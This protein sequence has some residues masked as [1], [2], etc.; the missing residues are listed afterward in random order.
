MRQ[1]P[2]L[3]EPSIQERVLTFIAIF[4][5]G[6]TRLKSSVFGLDLIGHF[7]AELD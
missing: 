2:S 7:L 4:P 5:L 6:E 1:K 3:F